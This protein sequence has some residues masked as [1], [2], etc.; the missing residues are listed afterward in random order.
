ME[1]FTTR[2][3]IYKRLI[4]G[5]I[6]GALV[7]ISYIAYLAYVTYVTPRTSD[8][9]WEDNPAWSPDGQ[10]IAFECHYGKPIVEYADDPDGDEIC[11]VG[12]NGEGFLR[13]TTNDS[14]DHFPAWSPDGKRI[15]FATGP[16]KDYATDRIVVMNRDGSHLTD[17]VKGVYM[18]A[19]SWSPD[20]RY[21]VYDD[22]AGHL[23]A[24][25]VQSGEVI[26]LEGAGP[27]SGGLE[28]VWSPDGRHI[29][30][31]AFSFSP[32]TPEEIYVIAADGTSEDRLTYSA[33]GS[34]SPAWSPDGKHIAFQSLK[35]FQP[36]KPDS[37]YLTIELMDSDGSNHVSLTNYDSE[38]PTWTPD[39]QHLILTHFDDD[40]IFLSMI[41]AYGGGAEIQL[42]TLPEGQGLHFSP[43]RRHVAYVRESRPATVFLSR[44]W[45]A[46]LDGSTLT[47]L[48]RQE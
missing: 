16:A 12:A 46:A 5:L 45:I 39:G 6:L 23:N 3:P 11:I 8:V 10:T 35:G 19:S 34:S 31:S 25:N 41:D 13:L 21:I 47:R 17:L 1:V 2:T 29:A 48:T 15:A 20:G 37:A 43:D 18:D 26:S 36:K 44:I 42:V 24:V 9:Y 33:F 22:V 4:Y 14:P 38:W 30:F 7:A 27:R 40:Q 32:D 28:A